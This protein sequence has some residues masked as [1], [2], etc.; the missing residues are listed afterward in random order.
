MSHTICEGISMKRLVEAALALKEY[1]IAVELLGDRYATTC[2]IPTEV[3][4][5][6]FVK[7][8]PS[9]EYHFAELHTKIQKLFDETK[10]PESDPRVKSLSLFLDELM[11]IKYYIV[12]TGR[13]TG[14]VTEHDKIPWHLIPSKLFMPLVKFDLLKSDE[15]LEIST[16]SCRIFLIKGCVKDEVT[17][18]VFITC[19][20]VKI[21]G[22]SKMC[23]TLLRNILLGRVWN[24]SGEPTLAEIDEVARL[25]AYLRKKH[26]CPSKS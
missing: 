7:I 21:V 25:L 12:S 16:R 17:D 23:F 1:P 19:K 4:R 10:G 15:N 13:F 18:D 26:G 3:C 24:F 6:T 8:V 14:V 20:Q 2:T 5:L 11:E 9:S 22:C